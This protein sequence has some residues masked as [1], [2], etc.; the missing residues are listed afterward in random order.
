[1]GSFDVPLRIAHGHVLKDYFAVEVTRLG[2]DGPAIAGTADIN[3][4]DDVAVVIPGNHCLS[5]R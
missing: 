2:S 1:M 3:F 5:S 4:P